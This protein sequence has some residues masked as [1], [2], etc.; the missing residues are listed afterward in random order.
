LYEVFEMKQGTISRM[1]LRWSAVML[2][3]AGVM[4]LAVVVGLAAGCKMKQSAAPTDQQIASDI[5]T[6][7]KGESALAQQ[8][9]QVSV[10]NGVATLNGTVSDEASRALAAN[11][12]GTIGGVKA[13]VN[14]LTIQSAAAT[15]PAPE[16]VPPASA[17]APAPEPARSRDRDDHADRK[18]RHESQREERAAENAPVTPAYEPSAQADNTPPPPPIQA[19]PP[20]PPQPVAYPPP[21]PPPPTVPRVRG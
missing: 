20:P 4:L 1:Q 15:S 2:P 16:Q 12:S 19:A 8:N 14:N 10:V 13:V 5:Q 3:K 11:D 7:I 9:I 6:K 21:P 18:K 17:A